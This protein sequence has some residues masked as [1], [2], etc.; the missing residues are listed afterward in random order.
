MT[1]AIDPERILRDL[2]GLWRD[3]GQQ[4]DPESRDG[5]LR[6]C[7]MTL[8]VVA[9]GGD[10][11]AGIGETLAGL[12]RDHP[13]RAI[14]VRVHRESGAPLAARVLAQCWLPFGGRKQICCEQVEI[15][16]AQQSLDGLAAVVLPLA[17][18]D[19]PVVLWLRNPDLAAAPE[20]DALRMLATKVI[21]DSRDWQT[22]AAALD[23]LA[24][25]HTRAGDLAWTRLTPWRMLLAHAVDNPG[26]L[27][28]IAGVAQAR[29]TAG[30]PFG[31]SAWYL[32][33]WLK[34]C[35]RRGECLVPVRLEA[36]GAPPGAISGLSLRG[37]GLDA[38]VLSA[39]EGGAAVRI[40]AVETRSPLPA[41]P[42]A[43]L[44]REEL[45]ITG[46]DPVYEAVLPL[47]AKLAREAAG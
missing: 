15:D 24:A 23:W 35:L 36:S 43:A 20:L 28:R 45:A 42:D 27:G 34:H 6:A 7:S 11:P 16:C 37:S 21:I 39:P 5:V 47:A 22:P 14:V 32:A 17:A 25:S 1:A 38:S 40:N 10:D 26:V 9:D 33:A 13:S 41:L 2:A 31:S 12:M 4:D 30:E 44:L 46:P 18:A 3:L 19:L 29:V 8:V